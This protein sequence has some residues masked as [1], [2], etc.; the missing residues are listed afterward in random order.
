MAMGA[1]KNAID[2]KKTFSFD[3]DD[4]FK[5]LAAKGANRN[6][7]FFP[8]F[9][10]HFILRDF[11]SEIFRFTFCGRGIDPADRR[12][13]LYHSFDGEPDLRLSHRCH[14]IHVSDSSSSAIH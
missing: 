9:Y 11:C 7:I 12:K 3:L 1:A 8:D 14:V 2:R 13:F 4:I 5:H 10:R 6:N